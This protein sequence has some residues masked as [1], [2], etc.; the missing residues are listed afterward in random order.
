MKVKEQKNSLYPPDWLKYARK[1]WRR[2]FI[3]L[4]ENDME[5]AAFFLQ[6]ALEKYIKAFLLQSGWALKKI[7]DLDA[8]LDDAV[9]YKPSLE[10]SRATG[11]P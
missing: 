5:A 11:N 9:K 1:D 6:Q 2:I 4:K 8:L 3:M 10:S 7:H